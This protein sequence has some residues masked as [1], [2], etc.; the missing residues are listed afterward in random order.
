M[1]VSWPTHEWSVHRCDVDD[2]LACRA[3]N[4]RTA[5]ATTWGRPSRGARPPG[6]TR[7]SAACIRLAA[8]S[9]IDGAPN[10]SRSL[11]TNGTGR[12]IRSRCRSV[13]VVSGRLPRRRRSECRLGRKIVSKPSSRS[14]ARRSAVFRR[15]WVF[16]DHGRQPLHRH[17]TTDTRPPTP[18]HRRQTTDARP[19]TPDH[20]RQTTDARPPTPD[21]RHQ[22][23]DTRPSTP[24]HRHQTTDTRPRPRTVARRPVADFSKQH[25]SPS[26]SRE[27]PEARRCG[28]PCRGVAGPPRAVYLHFGDRAGLLVALVQHMDQTLDPA[29]SLVHV[30][31][32][33]S[34]TRPDCSQ[35]AGRSKPQ[36][37]CSMPSPCRHPAVTLP[38]PCR[39]ELTS[40]LGWSDERY[41][42]QMTELLAR[43]LLAPAAG[44]Q[45]GR[46]DTG[47]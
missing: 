18:D 3:R 37:I 22:T 2:S 10:G 47:H 26:P 16:T 11:H 9:P 24:D 32:G 5:S 8:R 13:N 23:T 14:A 40:E 6:T 42:A 39:R 38:A 36:R 45:V 17:Q 21:H 46:S 25:T 29:R 44:T 35:P 7:S 31:E 19:P 15:Q 30:H 27:P 33:R 28:R 43:A 4:G 12:R 34:R 1:G 41:V 20:R